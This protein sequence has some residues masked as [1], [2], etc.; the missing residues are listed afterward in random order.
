MLIA[1]GGFMGY[2]LWP[3]SAG[4]LY[5]QA[6]ALMASPHRSDWLTAQEEYLDTLDHKHPGHPYSEQIQEWRDRIQLDEAESRARNLSSPVK[7]SFSEPHT[8]GERQYVLFD[9]LATKDAAE[10]N[11]GAGPHRLEGNGPADQGERPG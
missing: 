9:T 7:T 3:P 2:W 5:H 8:N 1:I 6:E 11:D 4:Y 10:G